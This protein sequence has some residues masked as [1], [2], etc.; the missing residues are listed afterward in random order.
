METH[1]LNDFR[2]TLALVAVCYECDVLALLD[3]AALDPSDTD[4]AY[5]GVRVDVGY[6]ELHRSIGIS[7]GAGC[8]LYYRIEERSEIEL[9]ALFELLD[10]RGRETYLA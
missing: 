2:V 3:G 5:I 6:E 1:E 7:L 8:V 10:V 9:L 4:P